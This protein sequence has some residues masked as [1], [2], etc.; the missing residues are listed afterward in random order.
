VRIDP[1]ALG[2]LLEGYAIEAACDTIVDIFDRGLAAQYDDVVEAS[3]SAWNKLTAEPGR[4]RRIN[5]RFAALACP[6]SASESA[7]AAEPAKATATPGR[8]AATV[9]RIAVCRTKVYAN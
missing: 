9:S 1:G 8:A 6:S 5:P 4:N 3:S 2:E 7:L